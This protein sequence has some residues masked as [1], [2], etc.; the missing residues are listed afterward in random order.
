MMLN[1]IEMKDSRI[2]AIGK[3]PK[4]WMVKK[5]KYVC[6]SNSDNLSE[7][8]SGNY[9]FHY[10]EINDVDYI[11]GILIKEKIKFEESPSRARRIAKPGDIIVSTVR[12]YLKAI[13]TVPN[14]KMLS[15]QRGFVYYVV[16]FISKSK[17]S[18]IH[19]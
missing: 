2:E 11:N 18:F 1:S 4:G 9:K 3:V 10:I 12:T 8:T 6:S 17:V 14:L 5:I 13:G 19:S 16:R 15:A 7:N